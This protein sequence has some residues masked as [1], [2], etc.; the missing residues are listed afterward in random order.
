VAQDNEYATWNAWGNDAWPAE[1]LIDARGHVRH[2]QFGEGDYGGTEAAIRSLLEE[3]GRARL[4]EAATPD[5]R[6]DPALRTTPETYLGLARAERVLPLRHGPGTATYPPVT[7]T[8]AADQ[9]VLGGT[10]T[11]RAESIAAGPGAELAAQV[12]AKDVYL[13]LSPPPG[14]AGTV[15]VDVRGAAPR[16][17]RVTTQRLYHL[18]Q[19]PRA[20]E[21]QLTLHPSRG[22]AAYAFTFG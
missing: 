3:A 14:G 4:P 10:W 12:R 15:R 19:R 17:V 21:L 6:Y 13:V 11:S 22:V 18:V 5:R 8:P 7:G 16:T 1:Y 2:V 20:E 9:F